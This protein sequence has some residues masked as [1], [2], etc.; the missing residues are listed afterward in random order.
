V[1][2]YYDILGIPQ[3]ASPSE[4]KSAF[5]ALAKLYHPD[6][7][8][9]GQEDFRKILRAYETLIHP[10]R[11]S[12]YDLKLKYHQNVGSR[13]AS[14]KKK[15]W[16]F[17]E[18][19]MKRRQ[20]YNDHIKKYSKTS[21][22]ARAAQTAEIKSNYNE[23]KYILFATPIAVALFLLIIH[24][25]TSTAPKA[26]EK[27]HSVVLTA[28]QTLKMGDAPYL[29]YFGSQQYNT[30][31]NKVLTIK[32]NTGAD[33]VVC[34]F[35]ENGFLRSCFI[36][37]G[38]YA[39]I[40]QLPKKPIQVRYACGKDWDFS[41]LVKEARLYGAFKKHHGFYKSAAASELGP[42]NEITLAGSIGEDFLPINEKEFFSKN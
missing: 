29:D 24:L 23:Y 38:Y 11:K 30:A 8:P 17:E 41:Q 20:Y 40:P 10:S 3:S 27:N 34:L 21:S 16:S 6:K 9:S 25:A 28:P 36:Q 12:A 42:V 7:N 15:N 33:V 2:N 18:K 26:E 35:N 32:N 4:I 22:S 31:E 14:S 39:E 37:D 5:R 19:E 1:V 13:P